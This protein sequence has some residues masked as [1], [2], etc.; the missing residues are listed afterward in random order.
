M[1]SIHAPAW[2]ATPTSDDTVFGY[3]FQST[4]PRG[5]RLFP[6]NPNNIYACFNP[7]TRVGC[8]GG[9]DLHPRGGDGVSI[10][11]PAWGATLGG[12]VEIPDQAVSIHAPAW[13]ATPAWQFSCGILTGFNP[14][15]RVGCDLRRK[16]GVIHIQ[17]VSIHAP[18]WGAT[19]PSRPASTC[20]ASFNPRTRVGCDFLTPPPASPTRSF[21]PRTRVGCDFITCNE[22][23]AH[24][25]VSIHAPAWGATRPQGG[26]GVAGWVSIHAPAWGATLPQDRLTHGLSHVSIHAPAWGATRQYFDQKVLHNVVSIHAPAWGATLV[27]FMVFPP[28]RCFNPRT[29]VGCDKMRDATVMELVAFQSTHPRGVRPGRAWSTRG[30]RCFNPRTRVGCDVRAV[31]PARLRRVS[32]HAPAWGATRS[33][34]SSPFTPMLFQSTHPRGVRRPDR[35]AVRR[36]GWFQSTHPRGVRHALHG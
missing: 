23:L 28:F 33:N 24:D 10:H 34:L 30:S 2:G 9:E 22:R 15:T 6:Q 32:I 27:V 20:C 17:R 18:A 1:V 11:A 13:G 21:N 29:R 35:W 8:D 3:Q 7:R 16:H 19:R 36:T 31:L 14:R 25:V 5:V 4:H 26:P 12:V